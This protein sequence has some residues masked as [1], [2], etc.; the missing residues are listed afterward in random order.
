MNGPRISPLRHIRVVEFEG[1]GPAPFCGMVLADLGAEIIR[2]RRL[3]PAPPP[4]DV[5]GMKDELARGR[6]D[7][8]LDLTTQAGR[9]VAASIAARCDVLIEGFRPGVMERLGL[10]P[11]KLITANPALIYGRMTGWGQDGP[12]ASLAGHDIN[13]LALNGVLDSI[14]TVEHG[15]VPPVNYLADYGGGGLVLAVGILSLLASGE[16]PRRGRV[17]DAAMFEGASYLATTVHMFRA[18]GFWTE[19]RASNGLDGGAPFYRCYG[20]ADDRFMAVGAI[21]PRF[22]DIMLGVLGIERAEMPNQFDPMNWDRVASL[23]A[24][25]FRTRTRDEWTAPFLEADCCVTPVLGFSETVRD[26]HVRERSAFVD[27]GSRQTP[28]PAP[29]LGDGPR[30]PAPDPVVGMAALDRVADLVGMDKDRLADL[31][32][33]GAIG[34]V[35]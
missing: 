1:M 33:N 6:I 15:P 26:A 19:K 9:D 13:Y 2:I 25:R 16:A 27:D 23:L 10:G 22:F 12:L 32:A 35:A 34:A 24:D 21:E 20:T 29:R 7:I 30:Q 8:S 18:G 17:V 3:P 11:D 31:V 4:F 14:G 5:P 28:R